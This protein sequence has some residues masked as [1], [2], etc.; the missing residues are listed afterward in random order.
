M[1]ILNM[2]SNRRFIREQGLIASSLR[3][4]EGYGRLRLGNSLPGSDNNLAEG[5][6][7]FSRWAIGQNFVAYGKAGANADTDDASAA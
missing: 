2:G 1:P 5:A 7:R 6:A 3:K 4:F